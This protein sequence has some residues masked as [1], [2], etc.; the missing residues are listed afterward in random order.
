[1][2][3]KH[4]CVV[5]AGSYYKTFVLV[6]VEPDLEA[7]GTR[8]IVQY[9]TLQPGETLIDTKAPAMRP[10]AGAVGFVRPRWDAETSQWTEGATAAETAAWEAENPGPE[11]CRGGGGIT[12][13]N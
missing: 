12:Q 6:L 9:Y 13:W 3:Y 8:E 1:M 4:C 5:D 11:Y 7:G 10:H 2:A